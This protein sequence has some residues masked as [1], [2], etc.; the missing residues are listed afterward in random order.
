MLSAHRK[1]IYQAFDPAGN[2][3]A[4]ERWQAVR[5]SRG[6]QIDN[7]TARLA[8]FGEPRSDAMTIQLDEQLRL[9]EVTVHGLFGTRESRVRVLG[10][11]R[12]HATICWRHKA[13]VHEKSVRWRDDIE[14]LW[15][16]PLCYMVMIWHSR[17]T[18]GQ[19]RNLDAIL[20]DA[21]TLR[22]SE[23]R[24]ILQRQSDERHPTR[25][26]E[27]LLQHYQI[28][29]GQLSSQIWCDEDGVIYDCAAADGSGYVL[30]AVNV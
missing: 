5:L 3:I 29:N 24:L 12:D 19:A 30:T 4:D 16:T 28:I 13:Q 17:L 23:I 6:V 2:V 15:N 8:P 21:I 25:F 26:G 10:E 14:I 18:P 9:L 1:G 27:K 7:E 20:L 22:P 11:A